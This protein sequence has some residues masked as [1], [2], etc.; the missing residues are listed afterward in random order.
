MMYDQ[1]T[2]R[3]VDSCCWSIEKWVKETL[4]S[5]TMEDTTRAI[6]YA[7][8]PLAYPYMIPF[9]EP[10]P[11][12]DSPFMNSIIPTGDIEFQWNDNG[13]IDV[14]DW[15]LQFSS[16]GF[17][18][19]DL[20]SVTITGTEAT[21]TRSYLL[22][23]EVLQ[24]VTKLYLTFSFQSKGVWT[25]QTYTYFINGATYMAAM[26]L[27]IYRTNAVP[28]TPEASA[29][30]L[31]KS[32]TA[33]KAEIHV[34]SSDGAE[35]RKVSGLDQSEVNALIDS[36]ISQFNQMHLTNDITSRDALALDYNCL[37]LVNDASG[38]PTVDSGA[39]TYFYDATADTY[40]KVSEFESMD[41]TVNWGDIQNGPNVTA[42]QI[43]EAVLKMHE[44]ANK[45]LLDSISVD[46]EGFAIINNVSYRHPWLATTSEW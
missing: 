3:R 41:F 40:T 17:G 14:T 7:S 24:N 30:Y 9:V 27:K 21:T 43:E 35:V 15:T 34:T 28:A 36:K 26:Q 2:A 25:E 4:K 45:A 32:A 31:V 19:S 8:S 33:G 46:A 22:S 1:L 20:G 42:A 44:H 23:E 10:I 11:S 5:N 29:M 37:V 6:F 16:V 39:A 18:E 38:D 13:L 12:V